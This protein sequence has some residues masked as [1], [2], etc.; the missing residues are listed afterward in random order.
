MPSRSS[1]RSSRWKG[2]PL[3]YLSCA[4]IAAAVSSY[5]SGPTPSGSSAV[6]TCPQA[7]QRRLSYDPHQRFRL[8]LRVDVASGA[9]RTAIAVSQL[10]MRNLHL[11]RAAIGIRAVAPVSRRLIGWRA[12]FFRRRALRIAEYG[13]GLLRFWPR[14][15]LVGERMQC[16]FELLAVRLTQRSALCAVDD[17]VQFFHIHVDAPARSFL[18]H[19]C[20]SKSRKFGVS[21]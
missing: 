21:G 11:F 3:P 12:T 1:I 15:E 2:T 4:I 14:Q 10:R 13:L 20:A 19:H 18:L 17:P 16:G 9:V 5:F 8:L 6:N 7:L